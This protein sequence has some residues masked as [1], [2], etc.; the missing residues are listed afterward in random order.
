MKAVCSWVFNAPNT[1]I[2]NA[3]HNMY[4]K[5]NDVSDGG[6]TATCHKKVASGLTGQVKVKYSS[7]DVKKSPT[8]QQ[9]VTGNEVCV[10]PSVGGAVQSDIKSDTTK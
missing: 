2:T 9:A 3:K 7:E 1:V 10:C 6:C 4:V 8:C 5:S